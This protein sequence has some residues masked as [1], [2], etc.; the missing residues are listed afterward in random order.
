MQEIT[1]PAKVNSLKH[2]LFGSLI[3]TTI[4]FFDF[5]IYANAAV[6]VFP[7]LFFPSA[8]PTMATLQSLATFSIAFISRP[9]GSA[10]FGHYGDKI[11][12]KFTLVAALLTMGIS[13][14]TIGFLPSYSSIGIAAP[15][16]LMLCRFGQGVGLGGE[17]GGAVL[18]AIENAPPNKR[19]WYGMFPQLGAPIGLLLSGGT[20]LLLTDSMSNQEFMDYGWRI[21]FIASSLLVVV[22]FYIRTK[23]TETPSFENSKKEQ[24]EV[25]IPFLTLVK[26]YKNQLLF[27]TLASITTF[28]VFYLMTVFT[29]SWATSDLGYEKRDFLL[30]QLFS[31]LFFALFIPISAVVADKIGRRKMLI[32]ATIAIAFFG[33][34]F[35]HFL[36]S[37][38]TVMVTF[39]LC[40]GMA[41]MGFTYGP[42]G[43][44][45][46]EL[47]P[48]NVRY[49]GASL[50]FNMAGIVG[51]AFAP[52][53]AI[54]LASTYSLTYVGFY[55]TIAACI[56]LFS[57]LAISKTEH[58]F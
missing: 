28:L 5:Y 44:F 8:D 37:G 41:L 25:K 3:G 43:T 33:F 16:L 15:L 20:F 19:A 9:L 45:L 4:E 46:S 27:G 29:L 39:F 34:F 50:T 30:I 54:W 31:V 2:I 14:V 38:S 40:T 48:T 57:L 10:F 22:G 52:M 17:W 12:R 35:S 23:I 53:I 1:K 6:L 51:A 56:S 7:Q 42:L 58:K 11:G 18:L 55:L 36:K 32:V 21:P 49:S 24:K 13:T 47:F 26:S